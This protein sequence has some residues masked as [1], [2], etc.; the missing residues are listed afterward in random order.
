MA[1]QTDMESPRRWVVA[2]SGLVI[3]LAG[4]SACSADAGDPGDGSFEARAPLPSCGSLVLD[5][6]ISLERAGRDGITCLAAALTSGK[7]GELKVQEPTTE[8]D[9]VVSYYRVTK[10]RTTE[11]Y[12]DSTRD[13]FG[14]V[15]WS[16]SSCS[17]PTSVLEV[18]C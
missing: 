10:Q 3:G 8:G 13:K 1:R 6:G 2:L 18:N 11:V 9:P 16:Y 14:D 5:Q 12:V 7:G 15:D 4:V 17:K